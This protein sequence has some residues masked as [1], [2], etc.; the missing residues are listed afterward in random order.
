MSLRTPNT[1][2]YRQSLLDLERT[3]ARMAQNQQRISSG[4]NITR[5]GDD[6]SGAALILDFENSIQS[7][8][9]YLKQVNAASGLLQSTETV[10]DSV[11]TQV[12]RLQEFAQ[13]ATDATISST[14][15]AALAQQVD[16]VRT[17]LLALANTQQQG[18]YMFSGTL[19]QTQPFSDSAPP[20]GPIVYAGNSGSINL[21]VNS[22]TSVSTNVP[23]NS[24]FFGSGGA[25][26]STDLFK[27]V[28][29]LR[30]GLSS[31]NATLIQTAT[32]NLKS[33]LSNVSQ[34][35]TDLGGRQ[36]GLS[37]L[38]DSLTDINVTLQT[39]QNTREATNY[40]QA[41]TDFNNDQIVQSA[42]LSSL[43]KSTQQNLF[44]YL[45]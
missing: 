11:I 42:T 14:G 35:Q 43:A 4:K 8:E 34:V 41:L 9:Q 6:P 25:G 31:G 39:L 24:V 26:S 40:P 33:V 7:N 28:T 10:V 15:Q 32:A 22:S 45:G 5:P 17:T 12:T 3:K 37:D 13:Q 16:S 27:A 21:D 29:D 2:Q 38:Q 23:G 30:D 36:A 20:A 18:K 1:T 44:D 19:T